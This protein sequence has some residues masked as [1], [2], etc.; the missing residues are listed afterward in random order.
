MI[1]QWFIAAT[2]LLVVLG[3]CSAVAQRS[4]AMRWALVLLSLVVIP[5][6]YMG[7]LD[8]LSRPK[9]ESKEYLLY[10][11]HKARVQGFKAVAGVGL[12]LWLVNEKEWG[13][14]PRA[15]SYPWNKET[16]QMIRQLQEAWQQAQQ[17]GTAVFMY[18]PFEP[19]LNKEKPVFRHP[20]PPPRLPPKDM[21][22]QHE[23]PQP[24]KY[25]T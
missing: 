25:Q 11:T 12:Y 3:F 22:R 19:S 16:R 13:P 8:L 2:A 21:F 18:N 4:R 23:K 1:Y 15:F 10:R 9:P 6:A 17:Q 20:P 7:E 14:A 24:K 5:A